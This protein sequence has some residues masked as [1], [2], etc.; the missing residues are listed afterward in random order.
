MATPLVQLFSPDSGSDPQSC[1]GQGCIPFDAKTG[2][3]EFTR[4]PV[5]AAYLPLTFFILKGCS[6][7]LN[8][9]VPNRG[10]FNWDTALN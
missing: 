8:D 10:K 6:S 5:S 2:C 1:Y 7:T 9:I 3:R 4:H